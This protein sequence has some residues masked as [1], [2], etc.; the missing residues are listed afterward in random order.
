MTDIKTAY[1]QTRDVYD[2]HATRWDKERDRSLYERAWLDRLLSHL[3]THPTLLDLGC[4]S[5]DPI[6]GYLLSRGVDYTGLD[7]SPAMIARA[8]KHHPKAKWITGDIRSFDAPNAYDAVLSWDGFFHLSQAEQRAALPKITQ[9]LKSGGA[10][11]MTIG[12]RAGEVT[13]TIGGQTVYHAS[14]EPD[15]YVE[16]LKQLGFDHVGVTIDDPETMG[17]TLLLATGY[18]PTSQRPA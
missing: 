9:S 14:L 2:R 4:G 5:G 13:G 1:A 17:R 8:K 16:T 18:S 3:P 12:P 6:A 15:A 7:Y 10:L 11:L